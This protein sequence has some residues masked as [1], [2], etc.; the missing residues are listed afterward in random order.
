MSTTY[1]PHRQ[2][3]ADARSD[4]F[5]VGMTIL[6][7][8]LDWSLRT[9]LQA[10]ARL[11][12]GVWL[13][14]EDVLGS[15]TAEQL[16]RWQALDPWVQE[17]LTAILQYDYKLRPLASHLLIKH[18]QPILRASR[19]PLQALVTGYAAQDER[20]R[21]ERRVKRRKRR[22]HDV[23]D[24]MDIDMDAEVEE[25]E[26]QIQAQQQQ[27]QQQQQQALVADLLQMPIL[28]SEETAMDLDL[29]DNEPV[30]DG[31]IFSSRQPS[32]N[33]SAVVEKRPKR[34]KQQSNSSKPR[35]VDLAEQARR[36]ERDQARPVPATSLS[37]AT[38]NATV[39]HHH[40]VAVSPSPSSST[41][42]AAGSS[43]RNSIIT[44]KQEPRSFAA[45]HNAIA[46]SS[47]SS[48]SAG[49]GQAVL[50]EAE[51]CIQLFFQCMCGDHNAHTQ[52]R[53]LAHDHDQPLASALLAIICYHAYGM[54]SDIDQAKEYLER[55]AYW[56][57]DNSHADI[58]QPF[59]QYCFGECLTEE[60][61]CTP[62][63]IRKDLRRRCK[64]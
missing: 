15:L 46:S 7:L 64:S 44:V 36:A 43:R 62:L 21:T 20:R 34:A 41:S 31:D 53:S 35:N 14:A 39:A 24:G 9:H 45:A 33:A 38:A 59:K 26:P 30:L 16:T 63:D 28:T 4:L 61:L 22:L 25:E 42:S 8:T 56:L 6:H 32:P 10:K 37:S 12:Q 54:A 19:A 47:A 29:P 1:S 18:L 57:K 27:A 2:T 17:T 5:S 40:H 23:D 3:T 52:L 48:S 55:C 13:F 58:L 11:R 60:E 50:E 51:L 49:N